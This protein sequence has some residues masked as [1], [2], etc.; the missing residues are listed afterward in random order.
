M[1]EKEVQSSVTDEERDV[2]PPKRF[3]EKCPPDNIDAEVSISQLIV[4]EVDLLEQPQ[5]GVEPQVLPE[6]KY[7]CKIYFRFGW[8]G[9]IYI[10]KNSYLIFILSYYAYYCATIN[11]VC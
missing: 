5:I 8:G 2:S 7:E 1:E 4:E 10:L 11:Y 6:I 9:G 3:K